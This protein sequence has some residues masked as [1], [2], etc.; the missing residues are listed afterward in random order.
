MLEAFTELAGG[1][2]HPEGIAWD[3]A[4]ALYAGGEAGQI[5]RVGLDGS[6]EEIA[7]T[8]GFMYG[9][10]VDGAS[11]VYETLVELPGS[12]PDGLALGRRR[13]DRRGVLSPRPDLG[14]SPW[15]AAGRAGRGPRRRDPEPAGEPVLRG[16]EPRPARDL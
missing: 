12:Q 3:P 13:L 4:G 15:G 14:R 1:L 5:Y 10:A 6:V 8:G 9:L 11:R 16:A 7:S 2:D